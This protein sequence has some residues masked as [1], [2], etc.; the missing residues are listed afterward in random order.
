MQK[1]YQNLD[2]IIRYKEY[3]LDDAEVM[4]FSFGISARSALA[5]VKMARE[6]GIKAGLFQALDHLALPPRRPA[7]AVSRE[8]RKC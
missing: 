7:G 3:F 2:E 8:S 4:V 6:Q 5:A 1:I